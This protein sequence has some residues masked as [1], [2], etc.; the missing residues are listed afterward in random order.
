MGFYA[1]EYEAA[2]FALSDLK[3]K[4][5][6]KP[7]N[8]EREWGM[9]IYRF[10]K[11]G[12]YWYA[13]QPPNLGDT[14]RQHWSP[15]GKIFEGAE[16]R[17]ICHTHPN[18]SPFSPTDIDTALGG[19]LFFPRCAV[20]MINHSGAYRYNG[21]LFVEPAAAA[22][23]NKEVKKKELEEEL[24]S[25]VNGRIIGKPYPRQAWIRF[26]T[27]WGLDYKKMYDN[28]YAEKN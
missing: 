22:I 28:F 23:D 2:F 5:P 27:L 14:K 25:K 9:V 26:R 15:T 1:S 13:Y 20:Y 24:E 3:L 4:L 17:A 6:A 7:S 16:E 21:R 8:T 19:G 10:E 12:Q 11:E 18:N